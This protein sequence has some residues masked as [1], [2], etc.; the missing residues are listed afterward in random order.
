MLK[1]LFTAA[2]MVL[3][4]MTVCARELPL[5]LEEC[6]SIAQKNSPEYRIAATSM[7]IAQ[8]EFRLFRSN[9]LPQI[10]LYGNLPGYNKEFSA[11]TQPDG[12]IKFQPIFQNTGNLGLGLT[13]RITA[14]GG[15]VSVNSELNRFDEF[16]NKTFQYN[17]TPIYIRLT[18][19]LFNF[20]ELKW[21]N[22]IQPLR[23]E[24]SKRLFLQEMEFIA[25]KATDY[26]FNVLH[27]QVAISLATTNL[28]NAEKNYAIE[29]QRINLGTTSEDRL[30]QLQMLVLTSRKDL[31]QARY[32][33]KLAQLYA[34]S[35]LGGSDT[36]SITITV[37]EV[38]PL[39]DADVAEA[40]GYARRYRAEFIQFERKKLEAGQGMEKARRSGREVM[41]NA[42]Y[43]L[44]RASKDI[45]EIYNSPNDQQRL[46]IGFSVPLVDWGRK[47]ADFERA[48]AI[49]QLTMATN[50]ADEQN[51]YREVA[52]YISNLHLLREN[53]LLLKARDS[54][55]SR[56]YELAGLQLNAGKLTVTD[57]NITQNE[58]DQAKRDYLNML[59]KYWSTHY[60]LRRLTLFDFMNNR[61]LIAGEGLR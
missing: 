27:A 48:R 60:L 17:G 51:I 11:V 24:E 54:L 7:L 32:D 10:L 45:G 49:E 33:Y 38:I 8:Q 42:S 41:L 9:Q 31:E 14:T 59:Q 22:K 13:Q 46:S 44:N 57:F 35:F 58:K 53:L 37:P 61:A 28:G 4:G 15:L 47:K 55:A 20:N 18:Q 16:R 39:Y 26:F 1:R 2:L 3:P 50:E 30:L 36:V 12:T 29:E 19:P 34:K 6:I 5:R 23:L 40:V 52:T 43:G 56:R 21:Q 25:G